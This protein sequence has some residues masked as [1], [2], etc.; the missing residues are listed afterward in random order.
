MIY[1]TFYAAQAPVII[2]EGETD[3][4]YLTHA[5]RSLASEFPALAEVM[6][7]KKIRLR[8]RL[9]K[10]PKSS[11][12]RLLDLKDGGSSVLSKFIIAYKVETKDFSGPGQTV[13]V[14]ILYDNDDGAKS[15]RN[16]IKNVSN[17]MPI[18]AE[19]FVHVLKNLYAVPTPRGASGELS[20]IEDFFDASVIATLV[21]GKTFNPGDGFDNA[22]HYSK[23]VFAHKV[24][25]PNAD[26]IDFTGFRPLLT[27]LTA[28]INKHKASVIP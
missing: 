8:V 6:P 9:Y 14:I 23:K 22:K 18:S 3:N 17:V 11:T 12:A 1:T 21:D 7:D 13:P 28:A 27:N 4:I 26:K 24:V 5:I 20:K 25:R 2:C 10:Y 19:P 15:V 16:T